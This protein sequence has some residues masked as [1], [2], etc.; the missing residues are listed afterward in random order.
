MMMLTGLGAEEPVP[1]NRQWGG[2]SKEEAIG[3]SGVGQ[4]PPLLGLIP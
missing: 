2:N 4:P 3:R 1:N